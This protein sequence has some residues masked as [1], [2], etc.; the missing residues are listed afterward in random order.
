MSKLLSLSICLRIFWFTALSN[1]IST[2]FESTKLAV[3]KWTLLLREAP[4]RVRVY[5]YYNFEIFLFIITFPS[6]YF[7]Q[8]ATIGPCSLILRIYAAHI[9][10]FLNGNKCVAFRSHPL[11][12]YLFVCVVCLNMLSFLKEKQKPPSLSTDILR[13]KAFLVSHRHLLWVEEILVKVCYL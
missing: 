6:C 12:H 5:F 11:Q 3:S 2:F 8:P 7:C 1:T 4:V 13:T 9:F 10:N